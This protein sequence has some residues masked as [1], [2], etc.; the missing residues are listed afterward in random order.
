[1][2]SAPTSNSEHRGNSLL[3]KTKKPRT[4]EPFAPKGDDS[5]VL[6]VRRAAGYLPLAASFS[7]E[8]AET[9]TL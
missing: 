7:F 8:P 3:S 6:G 2:P 9:F 5:G 1:M 4:P